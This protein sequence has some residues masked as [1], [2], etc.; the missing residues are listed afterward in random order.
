MA[1]ILTVFGTGEGQTAKIADSI[2][3]EFKARDHKATGQNEPR[4]TG[5][6]AERIL[7]SLR[8]VRGEE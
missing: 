4:R 8:C 6:K 5:E 7:P 1:T 3:E 2:T